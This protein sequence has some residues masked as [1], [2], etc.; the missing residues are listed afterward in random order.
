MN[1]RMNRLLAICVGLALGATDARAA[2]EEADYPDLDDRLNCF[3]TFLTLIDGNMTSVAGAQ[4]TITGLLDT[5]TNRVN[6]L[7]AE[8]DANTAGVADADA[9]SLNAAGSPTTPRTSPRWR[10]GGW[11]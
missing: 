11:T 5:L 1:T 3:D 10:P 9:T 2:C 6:N 7:D 8:V 4:G